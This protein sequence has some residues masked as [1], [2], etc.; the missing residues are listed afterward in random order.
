MN[1]NFWVL[2]V[3]ATAV[4]FGGGC[5]GGSDNPAGPGDIAPGALFDGSATLVGEDGRETEVSRILYEAVNLETD[6]S[7]P[8]AVVLFV[9]EEKHLDASGN[10][11]K[12]EV[13]ASAADMVRGF[14]DE[15]W[16]A[17]AGGKDD[18]GV[19]AAEFVEALRKYNIPPD[20]FV[21]LFG[22]AGSMSELYEILD[23]Y[24]EVFFDADGADIFAEI[25]YFC[26][27]ADIS[28]TE[29]FTLSKA[30]FGSHKAFCE[31]A[32]DVGGFGNGA[33]LE[34]FLKWKWNYPEDNESISLFFAYLKERASSG[35]LGKTDPVEW[36]KLGLDV[37]K[38]GWDVVK[39]GK[40]QV[41]VDGA[42]TAVLKKGT[43]ALDY[44]YA[45]RSVT[46]VI[47]FKVTDAW[48]KSWTLVETKFGGSASYD[49]V[50]PDFGGRYLQSVQFDVE[51]AYAQWGMSLNV[52]AQVSN[53]TNASSV[54]N[55]DPEIDVAA[56]INA[57]WLF[58][59]W[60]RSA[61]FRAKGSEGIRFLR[62][63]E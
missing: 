18:A 15:H 56:R 25:A 8:N 39:D 54:E 40:P 17:H 19:N 1:K 38:F 4:M 36:G 9:K 32:L 21:E 30:A 10:M 12:S 63:G 23:A 53:V 44:G 41:S 28:M 31:A 7:L 14:L 57:G 3:L 26:D 33:F 11:V 60:G 45:K 55:P 27:F 47:H 2:F 5:G 50:N 16:D 20:G 48:I 49:A 46:P 37:L 34:E 61:Y 62:W 24:K 59:S 35:A 43:S 6:E 51:S 42:F 13:S 29:F 58:Q 52:S 22:A